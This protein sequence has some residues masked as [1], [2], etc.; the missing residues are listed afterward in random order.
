MTGKKINDEPKSGCNRIKNTG[1]RV[2]INGKRKEERE[3]SL[4]PLS[5]R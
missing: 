3:E 4:P 5:F 1:I 2:I